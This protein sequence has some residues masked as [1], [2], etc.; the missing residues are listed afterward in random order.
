MFPIK[1]QFRDGIEVGGVAVG[2]TLRHRQGYGCRNGNG[3][4]GNGITY[5]YI[6]GVVVKPIN[7]SVQA[8]M[9]GFFRSE[10]VPGSKPQLPR[11][12]RSSTE[13]L[14]WLEMLTEGRILEECSFRELFIQKL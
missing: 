11:L 3:C 13:S 5:D 12:L 1:S 8:N 9:D 7:E 4:C 14:G 2:P 6:S 10:W